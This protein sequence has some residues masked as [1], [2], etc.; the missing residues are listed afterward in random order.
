METRTRS[1]KL[2]VGL[3][4]YRTGSFF[5]SPFSF[6][7]REISDYTIYATRT[8]NQATHHNATLLVSNTS[9]NSKHLQHV[10]Q[11]ATV[12]LQLRHQ[13]FLNYHSFFQLVNA[14]TIHVVCLLVFFCQIRFTKSSIKSLKGAFCQKNIADK[15]DL[16]KVNKLICWFQCSHHHQAHRQDSHHS[17]LDHHHSVDHS[18]QNTKY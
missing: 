9:D 15:S 7:K 8:R 14:W 6:A 13:I 12:L 1:H 5:R 18:E 4:A 11:A 2:K 17:V 10:K 3:V 16:L